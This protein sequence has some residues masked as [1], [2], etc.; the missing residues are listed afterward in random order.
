MI[1]IIFDNNAT[2]L[3]LLETNDNIS[4]LEQF[5]YRYHVAI[6]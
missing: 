3:S 2:A 4:C 6:N 5:I 1:F